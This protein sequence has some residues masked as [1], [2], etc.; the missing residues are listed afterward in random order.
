MGRVNWKQ[1]AGK[2]DTQLDQWILVNDSF[3][4]F[5]VFSFFF[6]WEKKEEIRRYLRALEV[7]STAVDPYTIE[8]GGN[9]EWAH[10][11]SSPTAVTTIR[12]LAV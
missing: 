9:R 10:S 6:S 3:C 7:R 12:A 4:V 8:A 11:V 1:F 2:I 5:D